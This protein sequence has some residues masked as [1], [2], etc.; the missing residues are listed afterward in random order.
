MLV[1]VILVDGV[2]SVALVQH[3]QLL[4]LPSARPAV[5]VVV[6]DRPGRVADAVA[7]QPETPA[8]VHILIKEKVVVIQPSH[9]Q[10]G[11]PLD[12]HGSAAGKEHVP[13]ALAAGGRLPEA[14]LEAKAGQGGATT[15][16]VHARTV[17]AQDPSAR[18]GYVRRLGH[19]RNQFLE[20]PRI[21]AGVVVDKRDQ[22]GIQLSRCEVVSGGETQVHGRADQSNVRKGLLDKAG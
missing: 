12:D 20:P 11:A 17:P 15:G 21:G 10:I 22:V 3:R 16:E 7:G 19:G 14:E 6:D 9:L 2:K 8:Q 4:V 1:I 13:L 18:A 5:M